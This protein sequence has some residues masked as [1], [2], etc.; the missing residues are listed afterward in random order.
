MSGYPFGAPPRR[1]RRRR[2][3]AALRVG[4]V[5]VGLGLVFALGVAVGEALH[6]DGPQRGV[7]QTS[8]RTLEPLPQRP[9]R[10]P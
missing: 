3:G 1:G 9:A 7:T 8:T 5:L 10:S 4:L 6:E 2:R